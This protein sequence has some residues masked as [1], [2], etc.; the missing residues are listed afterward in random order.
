MSSPFPILHRNIFH[1]KITFSIFLR[2]SKLIAAPSRLPRLAC[3]GHTE[4]RDH[5]CPSPRQARRGILL[6]E[7]RHLRF[8]FFKPRDSFVQIQIKPF[9]DF[10]QRTIHDYWRKRKKSVTAAHLLIRNCRLNIRKCLECLF[11][12]KHRSHKGTSPRMSGH[13]GCRERPTAPLIKDHPE[14]PKMETGT[15]QSL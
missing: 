13:T 2:A 5:A 3:R 7:E 6:G 14:K 9:H 1:V 8:P 12:W 15:P 10:N 11:R 4:S